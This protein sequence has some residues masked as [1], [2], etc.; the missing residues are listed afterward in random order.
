MG[1]SIQHH[2]NRLPPCTIANRRQRRH[3]AMTPTCVAHPRTQYL[4]LH[5]QACDCRLQMSIGR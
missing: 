4:S 1:S 5:T 3:P 2:D